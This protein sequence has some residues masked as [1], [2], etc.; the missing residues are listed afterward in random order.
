V[1][2][3]PVVIRSV[4]I[5]GGF[6]TMIGVLNVTPD[7]FSDG[8]VHAG[9]EGAVAAGLAMVR[10]GASVVDVGGESTRPDAPP[11]SALEE[12]ER[13]LPVIRALGRALRAAGLDAPLSIDTLKA[14]VADA[15]L[16]AGAEIVN[17]VSGGVLDPDLLKVAAKHG[18]PVILGHMR[19][20]PATMMKDVHFDDVEAEVTEELSR[21][22]DG[23]VD[24]GIPRDRLLVD[25]GIGFGKQLPHNLALLL[26]AG[27]IAEK[28][29]RPIVVG[30]S[31]KAFL[32]KI[33]GIERPDQRDWAT[34]AAVTAAILAGAD[35]VRVHACAELRATVDVADA[36]ALAGDVK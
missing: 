20:T 25:P 23:A 26:G 6:T 34:A 5:G 28:L 36:L 30:P 19:G 16:T 13:V 11:V 14:E 15:A 32:G 3:N 12:K 29:D 27:R 1:A 4:T 21:R 17:D 9:I 31:R 24:A 35:A 18:A 8:G 7:S 22:L 33:T 2:K 10:A